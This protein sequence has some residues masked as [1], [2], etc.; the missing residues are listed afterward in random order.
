MAVR[1][2]A[3]FLHALSRRL[4]ERAPLELLASD[5]DTQH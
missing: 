2:M 1:V 4:G 3:D 5:S